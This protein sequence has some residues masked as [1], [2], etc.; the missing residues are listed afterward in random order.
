MKFFKKLSI[1]FTFVFCA[2]F[3]F[4]CGG[5]DTPQK[6]QLDYSVSVNTQ[7]DYVKVSD[8]NELT[9][10]TS[11]SGENTI[12]IANGFKFS[13]HMYMDLGEGSSMTTT[14][15]AIFIKKSESDFEMG[16]KINIDT[17][18]PEMSKPFT[19]AIT[20]FKPNTN[21]YTSASILGKTES[22][23]FTQ[24]DIDSGDASLEGMEGI[25][26]FDFNKTLAEIDDLVSTEN[27]I[28]SKS[29]TVENDKTITKYKVV[30]PAEVDGNYEN[31]AIL[32]FEDGVFTGMY[33]SVDVMGIVTTVNL[34]PYTGKIEYPSFNGYKH[35]SEMPVE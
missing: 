25:Q 35:I 28:I 3:L 15:N 17:T 7:G 8:K 16:M 5:S 1:V 13:M 21:F 11:E 27:S 6:T 12:E 32:T 26:N 30:V 34:V 14:A 9:Q 22:Y 10:Y 31:T 18:S 2:C 24:E 33:Y 20:M 29:E 19:I 4:A 23:Y